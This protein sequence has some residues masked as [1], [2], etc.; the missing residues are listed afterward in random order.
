MT[1]YSKAVL[2]TFTIELMP[3]I[4]IQNQSTVFLLFCSQDEDAEAQSKNYMN[5]YLNELKN[6]SELKEKVLKLTN[7]MEMLSE[8]PLSQFSLIHGV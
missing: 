6:S 4:K 8:Y 5:D 1:Y 2:P 7:K 3:Y